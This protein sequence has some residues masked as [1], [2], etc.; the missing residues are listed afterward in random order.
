M[1]EAR[2]VLPMSYYEYD[3]PPMSYAEYNRERFGPEED[4]RDEQGPDNE[5]GP[6]EGVLPYEEE[7]EE[8]EL[9]MERASLEAARRDA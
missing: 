5:Y 6:F 1:L 7:N 8:A 2:R 4:Y 3:D 9:L